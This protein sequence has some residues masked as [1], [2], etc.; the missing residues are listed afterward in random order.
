MH[1]ILIIINL[2]LAPAIF[3]V[4]SDVSFMIE[5][6]AV[7][8]KYFFIVETTVP[9]FKNDSAVTST[10]VRFHGCRPRWHLASAASSGKTRAVPFSDANACAQSGPRAATQV[11]STPSCSR[12]GASNAG[13]VMC[14]ALSAQKRSVDFVP[15]P[16]LCGAV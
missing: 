6:T 1:A 10:V 13:G 5:P 15:R 11:S 16:G 12:A 7:T 3:A 14:A 8:G 4:S 9:V 2:P